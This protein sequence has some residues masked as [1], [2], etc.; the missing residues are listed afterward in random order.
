MG[1]LLP[2]LAQPRVL[3]RIDGSLEDTEPAQRAITPRD[4]LTFTFGFGLA[5]EMFSAPTP[6]PVVE[7]MA[8][9]SRL[10]TL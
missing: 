1:R 9:R 6:W 5:V 7:A 2:E 8:V 10:A 3:R 4:L